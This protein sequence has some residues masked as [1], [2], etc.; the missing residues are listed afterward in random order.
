MLSGSIKNV[1][2]PFFPL[3]LAR[4]FPS[5]VFFTSSMLQFSTKMKI[6]EFQDFATLT[7]SLKLF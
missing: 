3:T 5:I 6:R 2:T 4:K 1:G 7:E